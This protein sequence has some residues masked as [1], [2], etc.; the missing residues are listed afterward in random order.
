M[1]GRHCASLAHPSAAAHPLGSPPG[2]PAF[3]AA[4]PLR[5]HFTSTPKCT[6]WG[7]A[8]APRLPG[9]AHGGPFRAKSRGHS[10]VLDTTGLTLLV[11]TPLSLRVSGVTL[12]IPAA[13]SRAHVS[14]AGSSLSACLSMQVPPTSLGFSSRVRWRPLA[15]SPPLLL[16]IV[17][18]SATPI[19]CLC[20][21]I[22]HLSIIPGYSSASY[23]PPHQLRLNISSVAPSPAPRHASP[24]SHLRRILY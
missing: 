17:Y 1:G 15:G 19:L 2:P 16:F 21:Q 24:L 9:P 11:E 14:L 7:P 3:T 22:S 10:R 5:S 8:A 4:L 6:H 23:L 20:S 18:T 13:F 12:P